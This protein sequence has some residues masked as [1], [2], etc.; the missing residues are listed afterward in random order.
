MSSEHESSWVPCTNLIES[1]ELLNTMLTLIITILVQFIVTVTCTLADGTRNFRNSCCFQSL[2]KGND[3]SQPGN[4]NTG[5]SSTMY[6]SYEIS[7]SCSLR[8]STA[9]GSHDSQ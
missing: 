3:I 8:C 9:Y 4:V 1:L 6:N 2:T 5:V 7:F